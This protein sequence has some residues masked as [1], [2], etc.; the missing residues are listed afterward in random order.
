MA[1]IYEPN[2]ISFI[3]LLPTLVHA[4]HYWVF[5][6]Y[7]LIGLFFYILIAYNILIFVAASVIFFKCHWQ[8]KHISVRCPLF[9][10]LVY[11]ANMMGH[12]YGPSINF[13][14]LDKV[15]FVEA[16]AKSTCLAMPIYLYLI[17][18]CLFC[19]KKIK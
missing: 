4:L 10:T 17:M 15:K 18:N 16:I 6:N 19:Y 12:F 8:H 2:I 13:D 7:H 1:T 5:Y 14:Q 9:V 3:Y 11:N